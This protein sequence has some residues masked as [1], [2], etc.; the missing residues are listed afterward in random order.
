M[1]VPD[2]SFFVLASSTSPDETTARKLR[3]NQFH[4]GSYSRRSG[5]GKDAGIDSGAGSDATG[6]TMKVKAS[7]M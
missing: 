2:F 6:K 7:A 1:A 4:S 5:H 3:E